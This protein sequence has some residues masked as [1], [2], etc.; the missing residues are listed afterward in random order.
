MTLYILEN[1]LGE[2]L[3]KQLTWVCAAQ[4]GNLFHSPHRDVALN[5][6][7]ELNARDIHLRANVVACEADDKGRPL[8]A[9]AASA[10]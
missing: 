1:H 10:A 8:P 5:Q 3:D 6:L 7:I 4:A 2:F 9:S